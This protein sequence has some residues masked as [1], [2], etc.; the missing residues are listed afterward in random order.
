MNV[1]GPYAK[2][3]KKRQEI[4]EA[5]LE[6]VAEKGFRSA[7]N[8]DIA[9]RVSLTQAG[10]MHHFSS[11]EELYM[12][13]LK[14]RDVHDREQ[15]WEPRHDFASYLAV[16]EHN[17][18]VP[19]L[20]QLYIEFSAEASIGHHPA[21]GYFSERYAWARELLSEAIRNAQAAGDFG[22]HIDVD[23]AART[24]IA[25]SDGLQQQWLLDPSIDMVSLLS[26]LWDALALRSHTFAE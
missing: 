23:N 25:A 22:P 21:H 4:L 18:R 11:R 10:L 8:Q 5:A 3:R 13:V 19:G 9:Q 2:G 20:V 16:I 6:V 1:R 15:F 7:F 14:A 12:E 24:L 17:T 26:D